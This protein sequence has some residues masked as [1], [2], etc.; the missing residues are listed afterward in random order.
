[1]SAKADCGV[2]GGLQMTGRVGAGNALAC[3]PKAVRPIRGGQL[4]PARPKLCDVRIRRAITPKAEAAG[5]LREL[6]GKAVRA[7]AREIA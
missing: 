4:S 3:K 2:G 6:A 7:A 5:R 1:M